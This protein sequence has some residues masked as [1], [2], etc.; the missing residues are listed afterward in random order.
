[1]RFVWLPYTARSVAEVGT[2][3]GG[4]GDAGYRCRDSSRIFDIQTWWPRLD[5][6]VVFEAFV[7]AYSPSEKVLHA[8]TTSQRRRAAV[9]S[10]LRLL[11]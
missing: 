9:H 8:T 1:M 10:S 3:T 6:M 7:G 4:R 2:R 5:V 11:W